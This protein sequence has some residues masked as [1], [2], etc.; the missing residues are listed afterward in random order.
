MAI[1]PRP[2]LYTEKEYP[3]RDGKPIGETP[4]HRDVLF[5]TIALLRQHFADDPSLY[6]S[7]NMLLY[8]VEGDRRKHVSPDVFA[9][10]GI[11]N[12]YRDRYFV[13]EEGKGPDIVLE[14][15][16][17]STRN[18][19]L[20]KKFLLYQDILKVPEYFLFDPKGEYLKPPLR[21]YRLAQGQYR[22]IDEVAGR[23]PSEVLGLHLE[24]HQTDLRLHDPATGRW[25]PTPSE[26]EAALKQQ[27]RDERQHAAQLEATLEQSH[28]EQERLRRELEELRRLL[29]HD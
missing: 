9:T 10:R 3:S 4:L 19:D 21:G 5:D 26:V 22:P 16:S 2:R 12:A 15:S 29:R 18:D 25:L 27:V 7:G 14:I 1:T 24:R 17:H 8:Y 23:L 6:I 11:G 28:A 13:W 20:K